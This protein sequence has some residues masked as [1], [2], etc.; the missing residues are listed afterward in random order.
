MSYVTHARASLNP[1]G[2]LKLVTLV[3]EVGWAQGACRGAVPS[4]SGHGL[5]VSRPG[6]CRIVCVSGWVSVSKEI[7]CD[8]DDE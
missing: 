3:V 8:Y 5:E 1:Q 2:R 6:G 4:R 7:D